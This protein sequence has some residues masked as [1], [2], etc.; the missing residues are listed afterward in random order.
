MSILKDLVKNLDNNQVKI[1]GKWFIAKPL[2]KLTIKDRIKGSI[3]VL[4][5]KAIAMPFKEDKI[6]RRN[7]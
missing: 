4:T 2:N 5:G 1:K 6:K 7:K 3:K